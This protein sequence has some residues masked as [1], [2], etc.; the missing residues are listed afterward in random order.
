MDFY[1]FSVLSLIPLAIAY[2]I[3]ALVFYGVARASAG[4]RWRKALLLVL[5]TCF[6]VLPIAEELWIAWS[7]G[8]ACKEAGTFIYKKVQVDGFY[9]DTTHWWRQLSESQYQFVE[10]RDN[11]DGTLWRVERTNKEIRHFKI[12]RPTTR[13]HF[14]R[15]YD[16]KLIGHK[17]KKDEHIVLNSETGEVLA[18]ETIYTRQPNWFFIH[19]D[20]PVMFCPTASERS[21]NVR[22]MLFEN[23]LLPYKLK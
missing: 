2:G 21:Q 18:K 5:G 23:V 17:I 1:Y 10:S 13:Y 12:D 11:L 16:L 6:A 22:R 14:K 19:L 8:Q 7:F 9:D 4:K 3:L 15:T 20:R